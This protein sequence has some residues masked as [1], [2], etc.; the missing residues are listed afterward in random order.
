MDGLLISAQIERVSTRKDRTVSVTLGSQELTP[1][2]AGELM[3]LANKLVC[4]Y[5]SPKETLTQRELDQV[6]AINP[7]FPGK[8]QSQRIRAVLFV[9]WEKKP[10]GYAEFDGYYKFRTEAFI[11]KI[12]SEI[13]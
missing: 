4:V 7:E 10:E 1:S 13:D 6:D 11:D 9:A 8:S 2:K 3:S 5:I 12:K